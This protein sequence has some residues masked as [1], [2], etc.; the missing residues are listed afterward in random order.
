MTD[1]RSLERAARSFIEDGPTRAPEH[2]VDRALLVIETTSQERDLRILGRFSNMNPITRLAAAAVVVALVIGG[3]LF[4]LRPSSDVGVTSTPSSP[5]SSA[6]GPSASDATA[7]LAAYRTARDAVCTPLSSA[8]PIPGADPKV[9]PSGAVAALRAVVSRGTDEVN[10]LQAIQA[11]PDIAAEH[12]AN[13]QTLRDVLALLG[14]EIDLIQTGKVDESITVDE[15]TGSLSNL[16]QQFEAKYGLQ[17][18][19]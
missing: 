13:V 8:S 10:R 5:G 12:L 1:D 2:A 6:A 18:C 7:A 4:A 16:F 19:P 15:A 14:H 11:P 17:P 9:D 3:A